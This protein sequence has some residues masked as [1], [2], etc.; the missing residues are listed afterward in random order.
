MLSNTSAVRR[1][2]FARYTTSRI[3]VLTVSLTVVLARPVPVIAQAETSPDPAMAG[4][5]AQELAQLGVKPKTAVLP[6]DRAF[7]ATTAIRQG[8]YATGRRI[9]EDVLASSKLQ[10]WRFYP[11]NEFMGAIGRGGNDPLLL[12]HLNLWLA[13]EPQSAIAH[14]L[15]GRYYRQAGWG[16]R[17][18]NTASSVPKP[19]M[20]EFESDM[21]LARADIQAAIKL[22][23]RNPWSYYEMMDTLAGQGNTPE[24]QAAFLAGIKVYPNYYEL[25]RMRLS[26]L[27][28]KWGGSVKAMYDFVDQY[29]SKTPASSPLRLLHL[30]LYAYLV[31]AAWFDCPRG[32]SGQQC[33]DSAVGLVVSPELANQT[34]TALNLFKVSDPVQF[35][36]ALRPIL[37]RLVSTVGSGSSGLGSLMQL[38]ATAMG[39]DNRIMDEPVHN[40]YVLDDITARIWAQLG[41]SANAE[42]KFREALAD[43]EHTAFP[44]EAQKD[45]AL[46]DIF[47]DMAHFADSNSQFINIIVFHDATVAYGGNNYADAPYLKCY[48]YY[49]LRHFSEAITECTNLINGS[50]NYLQTHYWRA[51]A[52][53]GSQQW[54][55]AL[56]DFGP[57]AESANNW[58]RVGAAL[59]MSYIYGQKHDYADQ[60]QSMNQHPWLFDPAVQSREDLAVSYNNRCFAYMK[61]GQLQRALDDCTT[62][63]KYGHVPDA[64]AKQQE[65]LKQIAARPV[66]TL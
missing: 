5:V 52:Y 32:G 33:I 31:D 34:V 1:N 30:Q 6:S 4:M 23:P 12:S 29:A 25:Y 27:T 61:L 63:L 49:R 16:A 13:H 24:I 10:N 15:R 21:A 3:L 40:S 66:T 65:L 26:S 51:K 18:E 39:S 28:P 50:G 42:T 22:N 8:D 59:D 35:N 17:S 54:D 19:R 64:Y 46:A 7:E 36:T 11:F 58:F 9:A 38:A 44:D 53:E 2:R 60:L 43:A 57:V 48:A 56:A 55:A 14:L 41:N 62:S 37:E 45:E 20:D 47:E